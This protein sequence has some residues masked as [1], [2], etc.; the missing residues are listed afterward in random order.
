MSEAKRNPEAEGVA[1]SNESKLVQ[2]V[3][4]QVVANEERSGLAVVEQ[5]EFHRQR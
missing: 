3:L 5:T 1:S 4:A 2:L